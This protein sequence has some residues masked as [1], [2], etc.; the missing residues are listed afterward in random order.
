MEEDKFESSFLRLDRSFLALLKVDTLVADFLEC[1]EIAL[2]GFAF[3]EKISRFR[4]S[5]S[6]Q[7]L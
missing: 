3:E 4:E 7:D 1:T 6:P 2:A 5:A